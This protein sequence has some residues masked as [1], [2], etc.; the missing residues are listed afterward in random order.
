MVKNVKHN[1]ITVPPTLRISSKESEIR[2]ILFLK[3]NVSWFDKV[4]RNTNTGN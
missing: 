3:N 4:L 2:H 1:F